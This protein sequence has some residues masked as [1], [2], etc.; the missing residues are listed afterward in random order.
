MSAAD[1]AEHI[2]S[3]MT[4]AFGGYTSSGY[5]K[6]IANELVRRKADEPELRINVITGSSNGPLDGL[7]AEH[8]LC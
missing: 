2:R 6:A 4:V 7:F 8:D 3:G 5:P 1:A